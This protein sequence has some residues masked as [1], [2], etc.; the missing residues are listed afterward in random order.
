MFMRMAAM[1]GLSESLADLAEAVPAVREEVLRHRTA[2]VEILKAHLSLA[3]EL[4]DALR[5][6]REAGAENVALEEAAKKF[7]PQAAEIAAKRAAA[8]ATHYTNLG[9]LLTEALDPKDPAKRKEVVNLLAEAMLKRMA[10]QAPDFP[11]RMGGG[12]FGG[13]MPGPGGRGERPARGEADKGGRGGE[14]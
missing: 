2:L 12:R 3:N 1:R 5:A 14:F 4:D 7:A 13:M 8:M 9:K 6:L 11:G 10:T